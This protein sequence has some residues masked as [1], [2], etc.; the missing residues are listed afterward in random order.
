MYDK[1]WCPKCKT[2]LLVYL[3]N[4]DDCT[5]PTVEAAICPKCDEYFLM[6]DYE[7]QYEMLD[8]IIM[9]HYEFGESEDLREQVPTDEDKY[10]DFMRKTLKEMKTTL[11][12]GGKWDGMTLSEFLREHAYTEK[13]EVIA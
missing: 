7:A 1:A 5:S 10:A 13:G 3:G 2:R 6:G 12:S 9:S 8:E 4:W 11:L